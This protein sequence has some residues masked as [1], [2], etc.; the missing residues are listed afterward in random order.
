MTWKLFGISPLFCLRRLLADV[1]GYDMAP[2]HIPCNN[3]SVPPMW[4]FNNIHHR[5]FYRLVK[6][7]EIKVGIKCISRSTFTQS[8]MLFAFWHDLMWIPM[9]PGHAPVK[10]CSCRR[11]CCLWGQVWLWDISWCQIYLLQ[12]ISWS[13]VTLSRASPH[14]TSSTFHLS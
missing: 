11:V 4:I 13:P 3:P 7:I 14:M 10:G 1:V 12:S 5:R 8:N 2:C 6:L 9:F